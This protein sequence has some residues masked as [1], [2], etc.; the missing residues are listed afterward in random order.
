VTPSPSSNGPG[1]PLSFD[2]RKIDRET[3]E[4]VVLDS[5]NGRLP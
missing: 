5:V 3:K 1:N 2:H 4:N